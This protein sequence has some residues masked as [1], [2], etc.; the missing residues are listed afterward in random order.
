MRSS[1]RIISMQKL[2]TKNNR[3]LQKLKKADYTPLLLIF[4][5]LTSLWCLHIL[6]GSRFAGSTAYNTYTLQALSWQQG[7]LHLPHDY[8]WLELAIYEGQYYVSFPPLPSVVL[9]PL[10][11]IFGANTPDNLLVKVYGLMGCLAIYGALK[12]AGNQRSSAAILAYLF[13]MASSALPMM[14]EGAVWY[15]AQMLAFG[16]MCLAVMLMVHLKPTPALFLYA[17]S[18]CCRPFDAVYAP[19]LYGV[20][21]FRRRESLY[22]IRDT[23]RH[24]IPGTVLGLMVAAAIAVFNYVRFGNP[25]EFGHNYLPEFS[26]QGGIQFSLNHVANNAK[27]FLLGSPLSFDGTKYSVNAFGYTLFLACPV[28][29]FTLVQAIAD[30]FRK[31]FTWIKAVILLTMVLHIFLLLLHRTF[32][33]YQLGARYVVDAVPAGICYFALCKPCDKRNALHTALLAAVLVFTIVGVQFVHL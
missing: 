11:W 7:T 22:G 29:T 28:I 16:L 15:Q 6:V 23:L 33:G 5:V 30:L 32:G 4:S 14:L 27:T 25:L 17:L 8:P 26:F 12:S 9:L 31:R 21:L 18:V 24:L 20:Y 2:L 10:T 13:T 1:V 3:F 19:L